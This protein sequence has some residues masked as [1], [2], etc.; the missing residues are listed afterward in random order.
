MKQKR[1]VGGDCYHTIYVTFKMKFQFYFMLMVGAIA[2]APYGFFNVKIKVTIQ[3]LKKK[4]GRI[5]LI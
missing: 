4:Y 2:I 5:R 3:H 1:S